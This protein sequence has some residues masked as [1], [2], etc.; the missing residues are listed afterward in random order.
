MR[1]GNL[2]NVLPVLISLIGAIRDGFK[3]HTP[4]GTVSKKLKELE[5]RISDLELRM[6]ML[7]DGAV[8][9]PEIE[10]NTQE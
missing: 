4:G 10:E 5:D 6:A 8:P 9:M 3:K 1:F 7:D 2:L